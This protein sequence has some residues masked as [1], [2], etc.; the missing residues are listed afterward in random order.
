M[1]F[2]KQLSDIEN[3]IKELEDFAKSKNVDLSDEIE[4]Q[5]ELYNQKIKE[6]Y[7]NLTDWDKV[8]IARHPNRPNTLDYIRG[9]TEDFVELHGD[10][11]YGD[12]P[13]IVGGLCK[14]DG[15]KFVIIGHQKGRDINEK[16][17][18]NFGMAN[19]E[20]YRKAL[21]LMRIAQRFN[22]PILT[23]VDTAGAFPGIEAEERGQGEA[24]ARNLMKMFGVRVPIISVII[25]EGGSGGAL[26]LAVADKV[27]MLEHSIYSV[28]SPEGCAAILFKNGALAEKA[29][30]NLKISA[31][32]LKKLG[33][34][35]D[36]IEE[37]TGGA[38]RDIL[39]AQINLKKA[40]LSSIS[41]LKKINV[42]TL[43]KN[44]YNKFRQMGF[45]LEE[46]DEEIT[47]KTSQNNIENN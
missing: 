4:E 30:N 40:V 3:K 26:A 29:A 36:I 42:D 28:I 44:R 46:V 25:G 6:I 1:D 43:L 12:D 23:L 21:R 39:C 9:I 47:E 18:R 5:K 34:I 11:L 19:P 17:R 2:E 8:S 45:Y 22:I 7:S 33:I 24:I 15:Q 41:E 16:I 27:L 20:G 32:N 13:A 31:Q 10:R 37:P 38:H 35:D 14:I